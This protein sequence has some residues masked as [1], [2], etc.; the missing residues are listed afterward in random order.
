MLHTDYDKLQWCADIA[1]AMAEKGRIAAVGQ[2]SQLAAFE[3]M[4]ILDL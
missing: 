4:E 3:D 1:D 2:E